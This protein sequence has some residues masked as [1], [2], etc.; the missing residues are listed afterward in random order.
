[1]TTL[2]NFCWKIIIPMPAPQKTPDAASLSLF[3]I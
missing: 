1:M 3:I 2:S